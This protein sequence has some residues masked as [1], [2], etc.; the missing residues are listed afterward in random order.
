MGRPLDRLA[1]FLQQREACPLPRLPLVGAGW[2]LPSMDTYWAETEVGAGS[3]LKLIQWY[4][5]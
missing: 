5:C 3:S 2:T 1:M 4:K